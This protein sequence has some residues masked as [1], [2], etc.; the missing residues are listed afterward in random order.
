MLKEKFE[1]K[2]LEQQIKEGQTLQKDK[3]KKTN[4][5]STQKTK[6]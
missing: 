1:D 3:D 6:D 4:D 5:H 2:K